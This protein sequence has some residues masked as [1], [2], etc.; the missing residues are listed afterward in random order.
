MAKGYRGDIESIYFIMLI[1]VDGNEA[2]VKERVGVNTYA[3][4]VLWGLYKLCH[5]WE[6]EHKFVIYLREA[7]K[8]FLPKETLSWKYKVLP[9]KSMWIIRTLMPHLYLASEK[10]ALFFT[11][12]HY[13][14]P[15]APMPRVCSIM[16]LGYLKFSGQF[17]KYDYWQLKLWTA[18]SLLVSKCIISISNTT[19][20]DILEHYPFTKDKVL[21][22]KLGYDAK[23]FNT[24][25]PI[26]AGVVRKKHG[27][28]E[29]YVLFLSTLK[30]SKNIEGLLV[31]WQKVSVK[32]PGYKL[33]IAGK[34]GWM[35]EQIFEKTG[36]L[37]V[38]DSVIFTGFV[39]EQDKE[40]LVKESA[41]FV[42]PSF[43]EGFGLDVLSS[44]ASGV[45]VVVSNRGGLPEV[46]GK[47]GI[48]VD[49]ENPDDIAGG[50]S[51]ILSMSRLEYSKIIKK[52]LE[53]AKKFSWEKTAMGTLRILIN[54]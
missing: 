36:E 33:V 12:S 1:G 27:L 54:P 9:G 20:R 40:A 51:S 22:T 48:I 52:G 4:E 24:K 35:Y 14:P 16:D 32:F 6:D 44:L 28:P 49:P 17:R 18:W 15:L 23:R 2:N 42:L 46:A 7:P 34:K 47:A 19:K 8:K 41:L 11:P 38:G 37:V 50:I 53:Q 39:D 30:P 21:V 13:T 25:K 3:Y 45:P 31:A 10:P 29:K 43:W 5:K 26:N